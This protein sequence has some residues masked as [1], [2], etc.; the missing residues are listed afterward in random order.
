M[1]L[2][3]RGKKFIWDIRGAGGYARTRNV[4]AT[5]FIKQNKSEV[6]ICLD[7]DMVFNPEYI[8]MLLEDYQKGYELVGGLYSVRDG[9]HLTT[10]GLD[11]GNITIDGGVHEVKWLSTGFGLI[12]RSLLLK[13]IEKRNL[14]LMNVGS[15][16]E[17]WAFFEDHEGKDG[18]S[19]LWLSEDY[20]FCEKAREVGVKPVADT[21]IW[22]GHLGSKMWEVKD[23]IDHQSKILKEKAEKEAAA[24]QAEAATVEA[25]Q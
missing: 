9:S 14:H 11:K 6:M 8:D 1:N 19:Y 4:L 16:L 2:F 20:D 23:V 18:D 21:R 17:S 5:N 7:R 25:K 3:G 10:F 22:T 12:T 15:G 13:V 24:K